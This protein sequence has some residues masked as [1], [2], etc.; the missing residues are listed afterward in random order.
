MVKYNSD[1]KCI[2][3]EKIIDHSVDFS[4]ETKQQAL[5]QG[6]T[7]EEIDQQLQK[8]NESAKEAIGME[9]TCKFN[10]NDLTD[11]LN[12]WSQGKF[13]SEDFNVA[14]CEESSL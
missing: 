1:Y 4:E 6:T 10:T 7:Q 14:E 9:K 3:Y 2:Y 12:K 5:A 11:L 13:S 8:A